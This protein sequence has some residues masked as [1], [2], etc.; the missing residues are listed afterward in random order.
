[1]HTGELFEN[2][3]DN[4]IGMNSTSYMPF[5]R[6]HFKD[7]EVYFP[8][9]ANFN[10]IDEE[11]M[12]SQ[13]IGQ[14]ISQLRHSIDSIGKQ[15]DSVGAIYARD[16][17]ETPYLD[18][19]YYAPAVK[20]DTGYVIRKRQP[21]KLAKPLNV[22]SIFMAPSPANAKSYLSQA[23]QKARRNRQDYEYRSISLVDQAKLMRR[24]DIELQRKFTLSFAC[25]IFFFIGAP[26]GAIIK[27][28]GLGTPLVIS[29]ILFIVYYIFDNTG[30]KMSRDGKMEVWEG[31]WLSSA[32]LL[33]L[34]I[35]FTYKAVGD[36][37]V[38]NIDAYR[39]FFN[40][41]RGKMPERT[42]ELKEVIMNEVEPARAAEMLN[43]MLDQCRTVS[44]QL[45]E[46]NAIK[47]KFASS[48]VAPL[49]DKLNQIID[50]LSN[51]RDIYVINLLNK[52]PFKVTVS[53]LHSIIDTTRQLTASYVTEEPNELITPT[54]DIDDGQQD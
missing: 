32:A 18:V 42:L 8:F 7:K 39:N 4:A 6:E 1:M 15:V 34:G 16:L 10:R 47:R 30:Y 24:H 31:I 44:K 45:D 36:S 29:I 23:L 20:N 52:Y 51:S 22:D 2:L 53:N 41:L 5:R 43:S 13:Y 49:D 26:L 38:F 37:A 40:R 46:M 21:V 3:R 48:L 28:G 19:S 14:N 27:K 33:P 17:K 11:G 12:R 54:N 9:D 50:Y 25:I 35:F